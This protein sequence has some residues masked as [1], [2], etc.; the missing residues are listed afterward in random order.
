M[1]EKRRFPVLAAQANF[2][3]IPKSILAGFSF[4]AD[5]NWTTNCIYELRRRLIL[6]RD[7]VVMHHGRSGIPYAATSQNPDLAI[8]SRRLNTR[9]TT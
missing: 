4:V 5:S 9:A 6:V 7:D 8:A 3:P 2:W 1:S